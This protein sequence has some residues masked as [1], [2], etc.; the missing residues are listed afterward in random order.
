MTDAIT[1]PDLRRVPPP[2]AWGVTVDA[3]AIESLADRWASSEFSLPA[4]DYPGTPPTR[5]EEWWFDYVT[6]AVSVLACLWP[7]D[8]ES[9]WHAEHNGEW[10]DDAPGIFAAFTRTVSSE[11]VDLHRFAQLT[12]AEGRELFAGRGTLQMIDERTQLLRSVGA[13]ILDRWDGSVSN[14]VAAA[15][16]DGK[17]IADLLTDTMPGYYDRPTTP[18]GELR[19]DKLSHLAAAIMASGV[20]WAAGGFVGFDDFPVYPD[21]ML[22]RVFRHYEIMRYSDQ[23]A[24]SVDARQIIAADSDAEHAIRWATVYAGAELQRTLNAR[25]NQVS[26]PALDYRLW[27]VAVIG[28]DANVFGEHHRTITLRY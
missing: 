15:G 21:Y 23:L 19:F 3:A 24:H 26:A 1:V 6:L 2:E 8:G 28:P 5:P 14:L 10:L 16:R 17:R 12:E 20:G 11:G 18:A 25:R 9:I 4:F 7:P 27:S 13:T 22:P